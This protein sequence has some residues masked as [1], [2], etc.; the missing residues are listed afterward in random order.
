[1]FIFLRLSN[2][3]ENARGELGDV[4]RMGVSYSREGNS[5]VGSEHRMM[6][7]QGR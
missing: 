2:R 1:M 3:K 7:F 6:E 5:Q 4:G